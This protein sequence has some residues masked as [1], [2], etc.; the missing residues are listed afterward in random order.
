[1]EVFWGID[2]GAVDDPYSA[3]SAQLVWNGDHSPRVWNGRPL[4]EKRTVTGDS[5]VEHPHCAA[6]LLYTWSTSPSAR[7]LAFYIFILSSIAI[8]FYVAYCLLRL[9]ITGMVGPLSMVPLAPLFLSPS[10]LPLSTFS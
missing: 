4:L 6:P 9:R 7:H 1:M 8:P 2:V 5:Q 10:P 3:Y